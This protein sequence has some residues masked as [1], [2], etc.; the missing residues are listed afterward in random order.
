[1]R[2]GDAEQAAAGG[3]AVQMAFHELAQRLRFVRISGARMRRLPGLA[4]REGALALH[5]HSLEHLV[6][7]KSRA[8]KILGEVLLHL[9]RLNVPGDVKQRRPQ[10]VSGALTVEI[11]EHLRQH[12]RNDESDFR[13]L[14]RIANQQSGAV[15]NGGWHEIEIHAQPRE[16]VR[17][18]L[19]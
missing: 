17:H 5:P 10:V 2:R 13:I 4:C 15:L 16:G 7:E 18:A 6:L 12:G 11:L 1:M 8:A 9:A 3:F 14:K 19:P